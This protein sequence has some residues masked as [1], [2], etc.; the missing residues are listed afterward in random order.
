MNEQHLPSAAY[1]DAVGRGRVHHESQGKTFSGAFLFKQR[2][3]VKEVIEKF[4]VVSMLDYGCGAGKQYLLRMGADGVSRVPGDPGYSDD[5]PGLMQILGLEPAKVRLY[6]PC[7]Q[8]YAV[9]PAGVFHLVVCVQVL[10]CIPRQ[11]LP[12]AIDRLYGFASRAIFVAE[13]MGAARKKIYDG[14][15]DLMP[16]EMSTDEWVELLRRPGSPVAMFAAL[17]EETGEWRYE[18]LNG[19]KPRPRTGRARTERP[20][21]GAT[22]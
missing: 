5:D 12:W 3:R 1:Y 2:D 4:S 6:D 19:V 16:R 13:R 17:K 9:E 21:V 22:E 20:A 18:E 11:D 10:S 15:R 7:V 14:M 8:R